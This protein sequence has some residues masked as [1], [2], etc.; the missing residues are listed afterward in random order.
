MQA[1]QWAGGPPVRPPEQPHQRGYE[2]CADDE[3][4]D[5]DCDGGADAEFLEE[6]ELAGYERSERDSEEDRRGG[7]DRAG[8][9]QADGDG[10]RVGQSAVVGLL[11]PG[12]QKT[13]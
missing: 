5:Q 9:L 2:E 12:E 3:R 11:D 7:D 13:P 10:V 1:A 4:V 6:H 8:A